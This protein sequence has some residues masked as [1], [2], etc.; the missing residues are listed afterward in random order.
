MTAFGDLH[1]KD[2]PFQTGHVRT[3]RGFSRRIDELTEIN[4]D[5]DE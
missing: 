5:L 2:G 4:T 1:E 3:L